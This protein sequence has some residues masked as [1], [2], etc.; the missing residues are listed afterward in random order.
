MAQQ[1]FHNP[2]DQAESIVHNPFN[3]WSVSQKEGKKTP[4][5]FFGNESKRLVNMSP[6]DYYKFVSHMIGVNPDDLKK[7]RYLTT[8]EISVDDIQQKMRAGVTF[9]TPWLR[10][11]DSGEPG[12]VRPHWQEGL[13]RMLAAGQLYGMDTK[14]PTYIAF[15]N[16][17][18]NELD[19][20]SMDDFIKHYDKT[21]LDR[22]NK[23][24]ERER[25]RN[26]EIDDMNKELTARHFGKLLDEVTPEMIKQ[27]LKYES[28]E[29]KWDE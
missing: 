13:H 7:Q 22:Y 10:L 4:T 20:L 6:N 23:E 24:Q 14:F 27:Y 3:K 26:Q 12:T 16:D 15:E 11:T 2:N 18:W 19:T 21:R 25:I 9:D 17:P 1:L 29:F 8:N 5:Q 28:D